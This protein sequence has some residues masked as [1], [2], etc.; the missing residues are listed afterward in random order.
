[1]HALLLPCRTCCD[2]DP[3]QPEMKVELL[4]C[5][6]RGNRNKKQAVRVTGILRV[7]HLGQYKLPTSNRWLG[8]ETRRE[9]KLLTDKVVMMR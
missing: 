1:M 8:S 4:R 9:K 3:Q 7:A 5:L 2:R 6:K